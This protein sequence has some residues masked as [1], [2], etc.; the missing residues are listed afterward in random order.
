[1]LTGP[2]GRSY[3]LALAPGEEPAAQPSTVMTAA[4][5]EW[6]YRF[7]E[8]VEADAF[9]RDVVGDDALAT[10]FVAAAPAFARL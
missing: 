6:C 4:I 7:A 1:V 8:R 5:V 9:T 3:D 10:D 2:G